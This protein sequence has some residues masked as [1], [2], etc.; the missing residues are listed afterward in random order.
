MKF[1]E[2]LTWALMYLLNKLRT[3]DKMQNNTGA[4]MLDSVSA[5]RGA[6]M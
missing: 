4:R 1:I 5:A 2:D 3:R 6:L